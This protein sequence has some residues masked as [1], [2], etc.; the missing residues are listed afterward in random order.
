MTV[1]ERVV[2][3]HEEPDLLDGT[4]WIGRSGQERWA[5]VGR[6]RLRLHRA[7]RVAVGPWSGRRPMRAGGL[8]RRLPT[9]CCWDRRRA[10]SACGEGGACRRWV[11]M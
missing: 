4:N 8:R 7:G 1:A 5:G 11:A 9:M 10:V 3:V 2:G 6:E